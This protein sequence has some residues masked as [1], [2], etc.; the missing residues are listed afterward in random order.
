MSA[1]FSRHGLH[2]ISAHP[3]PETVFLQ[4]H[5]FTGAETSVLCVF[6]LFNGVLRHFRITSMLL[7]MKRYKWKQYHARNCAIIVLVKYIYICFYTTTL[8][9]L[10]LSNFSDKICWASLYIL[11]LY[12]QNLFQKKQNNQALSEK[13]LA[14]TIF[15]VTVH[16]FNSVSTMVRC[17][18]TALH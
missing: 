10:I 9:K 4:L 1:C 13:H 14:N 3:V 12:Q 11:F 18:V 5:S 8:T 7:H 17:S 16:L 15:S 6:S 2:R